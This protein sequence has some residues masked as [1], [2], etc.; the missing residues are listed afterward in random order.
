[1]LLVLASGVGAAGIAGAGSRAPTARWAT[2]CS[3]HPRTTSSHC[4]LDHPVRLTASAVTATGATLAWTRVAGATGY[5]VVA[6][7]A[8][9]ASTS[10][11]G[12]VDTS[13]SPGSVTE[14]AVATR[15]VAGLSALSASL[16]VTTLPSAPTGVVATPGDGR[17]DLTWTAVHGATGYTVQSGAATVASSVVPSA[18]LTGL[19][20]GTTYALR[21]TAVDD[22][23]RSASSAVVLA[24]PLA[25]LP[26]A[27]TG[28]MAADVTASGATLTWDPVP[29]ATGYEVSAEGAHLG[30]AATTTYT[31][32]TA[33][34]GATRAYAVTAV[35][36]SGAGPAAEVAVLTLP[37]APGPV[38]A[39]DVT[40]SGATLAW[41]PVPGASGYAVLADGSRI[42]TT[43]TPGYTD[44]AAPGGA[45]VAYS[46]SAVDASGEGAASA[47]VAVLTLPTAPTG[48]TASAVTVFG[49][50]LAWD[51]V[52]GATSYVVYAR[53]APIATLTQPVF[54]DTTAGP[55]ASVTYAVAAV[56]GSGSGAPSAPVTVV[57]LPA[58]PTGL[59][60]SAVTAAGAT[61]TWDPVPGATGYQVSA[62]GSPV[63]S[64][65]GPTYTDSSAA[66]GSTVAYAVSATD[67]SGPGPAAV[68]DVVTLPGTPG[69]VAASAVTYR[70]AT[71]TWDPVAGAT[72]YLVYAQG[73]QVASVTESAV[74]DRSAA[75]GTPV[76][77]AVAAVDAAGVGGRSTP[78]PVVTLPSAP[79]GLRVTDVTATGAT[80]TWGPVPGATRYTVYGAGTP[81]LAT[82]ATTVTDTGEPT[83]AMLHYTVTAW[84]AS[85]ESTPSAPVQVDLAPGTPTGVVA[86]PADGAL[87][88]RWSPVTGA[89]TYRVSVGGSLST[90]VTGTTA[91]VAGLSDG[92]AY[93]ITVAAANAGGTSAPSS[94][95]T[96]TPTAPTTPTAAFGLLDMEGVDTH[97]AYGTTP[98]ADAAQTERVLGQLGVRH[99]RDSLA[100]GAAGPQAA[101]LA[102]YNAVH[103]QGIGVELILSPNSST[104]DLAGRIGTVASHLS[105]A[106]DA[107]EAPN[108]M[109]GSG[110]T[111]WAAQAVTYQKAMDTAVRANPA[112][113]SVPVLGPSLIDNQALLNGNQGFLALGDLSASL[114][115]GNIHVYPGGRTPTWNMDASLAAERTVSGDH[116]VWVTETGYHDAVTGSGNFAVD[117]ASAAAYLPRLLLEWHQRGVGRANVYEL[118]DEKA[119]PGL[120]NYHMHFGLVGLDGTIK[121]QFSAL[122]A[123]NGLLADTSARP[124]LTPLTYQVSSGTTRVSSMLLQKTTGQ[125]VLFL[126]QD[127]SVSDT[128]T[129]PPTPVSVPATPVTVTLGAPVASITQYRP[130]LSAAAQATA[131]ATA[132]FTVGLQGDATALVI[133]P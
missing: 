28:L 15:N 27:P 126:W 72:S 116:S 54:I 104:A 86:Y 3:R 106:V 14:Y 24:A 5:T 11:T 50:S 61:L 120:T 93:A 56:D 44:A 80:L 55:G 133:Q 70:G 52:P 128:A 111:D 83:G 101:Q 119:D 6:D 71:L 39:S 84:D 90:V 81:V 66:A 42:G 64:S 131:T 112:I 92:T 110:Q 94:P 78:V 74:T 68:V 79:T 132:T 7:G 40:A 82:T 67:A 95:V 100:F 108:E 35:N 69:P 114:D 12:L 121:P 75:S 89:G 99:I 53:G 51:P 46:V 43:D 87:H 122:Q 97:S 49:A 59:T 21:V 4:I 103:A 10:A 33:G 107:I 30:S 2:Y 85:G 96:G 76:S 29:G 16:A 8:V 124:P 34:S 9:L 60:A 47:P 41:D 109:N 26:A 98:Y 48:L 130:S 31:D 19:V 117:D 65:S 36:P 37:A 105:T 25:P 129:N 1:M 22:A 63:G 118:Y 88:V 13:R 73:V 23:G 125:Y 91:T 57:T 62:G 77:Y 113:A 18:A 38:T 58:A 123:F 17:I 102:F 20:D 45:T 115:L 32:A 127:A